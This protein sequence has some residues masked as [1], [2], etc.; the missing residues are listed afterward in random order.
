MRSAGNFTY[1]INNSDGQ[2][3]INSVNADN[4]NLPQF[5]FLLNTSV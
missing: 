3:F 1:Y 5:L 2:Y 4:F